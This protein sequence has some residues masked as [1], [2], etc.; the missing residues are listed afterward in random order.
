MTYCEMNI[1]MLQTIDSFLGIQHHPN[2]ISYSPPSIEPFA[3]PLEKNK[4]NSKFKNLIVSI[5]KIINTLLSIIY[6]LKKYIQS[7]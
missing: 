4:V 1:G 7:K 6:I 3:Q 2:D 5:T